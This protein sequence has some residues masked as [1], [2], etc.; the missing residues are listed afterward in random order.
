[1]EKFKYK[2]KDKNGK[3]VE[4]LIEATND[5]QAVK[6][7]RERDLLVIN[8]SPKGDALIVQVKRGL[9]RINTQD[10]V[11]FTRQLST[12][13]NAGLTITESLSIL[14]LQASPAMGNLITEVLRQ[15]ESGVTLADALER[16]TS[17]FDQ[18]YIALIKSGETAG[19]LDK[20]L[21]RLADNLEKQSEF[22][23][24]IKGAMVYPII[25]VGGMIA[26]VAIMIIFVVPKLT[27]IYE[28]FQAD[29]PI[30]TKILIAVSKFASR[31]WWLAAIIIAGLSFP[32]RILLKNPLFRR[33][34][35]AFLFKVPVLGKLRKSMILTEFT[36][37]LGLL[38]GS[39]ILIV[40]AIE[41]TTK[42]LNSPNY[43]EK[44][45]EVS[46]EVEKG[47]PLAT[48]LARTEIFPPLLPQMVAVGEET[49][50]LDE[51]LGKVSTYF[52]QEADAAVKGLT[53]AIEPLIMIVLGVGV[54][55][56]M[57]AIIMPIYNLTSKF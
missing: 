51:I 11:N 5:K 24:K 33:H 6:I 56:L 55:F 16:H 25:V 4:G 40:E 27:V 34:F 19:V 46:K 29:L 28:E 18:I 15:V 54:G 57:M 26:V 47:L 37:T 30:T 48:A 41:V 23:R 14:E 3:T 17:V 9:G 38:V 2:A 32:L 20:V 52:E 43:E 10:K 22:R 7:L 53:T 42:S 35:D 1:M 21:A 13:I 31:F 50:K 39:G 36:R 44:M 49:G 8:L 12:M 45:K